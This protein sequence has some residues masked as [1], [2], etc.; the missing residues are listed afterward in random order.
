MALTRIYTFQPHQQLGPNIL[1]PELATE[2]S[3]VTPPDLRLHTLEA[4]D[5]ITLDVIFQD[6]ASSGPE[7]RSAVASALTNT[8][9]QLALRHINYD[10]LR[11]ALTPQVGRKE[12]ALLFDSRQMRD[13]YGDE[14]ARAVLPL[15]DRRGN[16]SLL[17]G[18]L[19][20]PDLNEVLK[21]LDREAVLWDRPKILIPHQIYVIYLTNLS[22]SNF[23]KLTSGVIGN[24]GAFGYVDCTYSGATKNM[25]ATCLGSKYVKL[26]GKFVT[27]HVDDA[28]PDVNQN[29]PGWPLEDL[30]YSVYSINGLHFDLF[31]R[32]KIESSLSS[33]AFN[34]GHFA[35]AAVAG[36]WRDPRSV[37]LHLDPSKLEY[38]S[39]EKSG[40]LIRAD[41]A[42]LTA[43]QIAQ[44]IQ[45]K[46]SSSYIYN[47]VWN[48]EKDYSNFAAMIEFPNNGRVTRLRA[49]LK[50]ENEQLGLVT[51]FG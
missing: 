32:Y 7:I 27:S 20:W 21:A 9:S 41:L 1:N 35:L 46:L 24:P 12:V 28:L 17:S 26:A 11:T 37:P 23:F 14:A 48:S 2:S 45:E 13:S 44:S 36:I 25:L 47:L 6:P 38:L 34:D 40:S 51:L 18:D 49:A 4:R 33:F 31:L 39:K 5:N 19:I 50:Y 29:T 10:E 30:G 43:E 16:H 42:G 22:E 3:S 8:R 15:I